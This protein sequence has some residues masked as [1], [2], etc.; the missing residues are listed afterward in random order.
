[1][2]LMLCIPLAHRSVIGSHFLVSQ[3]RPQGPRT[4]GAN[5][6][7]RIP[8]N[9]VCLVRCRR[10]ATILH[11][12]PT[13]SNVLFSFSSALGSSVENVLWPFEMLRGVFERD[14]DRIVTGLDQSCES[15][16]DDQDQT[17]L[18]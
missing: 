3:H 13:A 9:G 5:I 7:D 4:T 17:P 6:L 14:F 16:D 8:G 15:N 10:F 2:L 18:H 11:M 1:M 12:E